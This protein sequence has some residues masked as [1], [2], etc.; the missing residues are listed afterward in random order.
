MS[1]NPAPLIIPCHRV[2]RSD[3]S[4]GGF[5]GPAGPTLKRKMLELEK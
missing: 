2:V 1:K 5:S 4:P 3:G